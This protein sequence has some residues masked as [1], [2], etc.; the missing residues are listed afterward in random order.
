[1]TEQCKICN[2]TFGNV[3]FVVREMMFGTKENFVYFKCSVCGCLQLQEPPEEISLYYP[4]DY[5]SFRKA[6]VQKNC[7]Y[8]IRRV[9]RYIFFDFIFSYQ[10]SSRLMKIFFPKKIEHLK[11]LKMLVRYEAIKKTSAVLDVGCGTGY[12][13]RG[14]SA[15]GFKNLTGIDL[16][17]ENDILDEKIKIFKEDI[18]NHMGVYDLVMLH[19]SFEHMAEP[20]LVL[21]RLYE[22]LSSHGFLLIRIPICDSFAWRKYGVNWFQIDAPRHLFLHTIRSMMLLSQDVGF[23]LRGIE[24]DSTEEQFLISDNYCRDIPFVE[25]RIFST[26]GIH[27]FEKQAKL[28]N[29]LMDGDQACFVFQ[30]GAD[31]VS[32]EKNKRIIL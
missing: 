4:S 24:Y 32:L 2:N 5:G 14:M 8:K 16:Y 29:E 3:N 11:W 12:L 22:M 30:K 10:W 23:T 15:W 31:V 1:M 7:S 26:N 17:I 18:F 9:I 25:N 13:L 28:L 20:R 6:E 27:V 19:H 21:R